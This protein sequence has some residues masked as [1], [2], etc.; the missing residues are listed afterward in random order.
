MVA[1]LLLAVRPTVALFGEKDYQ[2]LAVIRQLVRDLA[3]PIEIVGVPI[4]RDP[5]GL[6]LSSRNAYL[7]V[8]E[9]ARAV[10]LPRALNQAREA[11]RAEPKDVAKALRT[12][13][14]RLANA[15]FGPIDYVALTD[16]ETLEPLEVFDRPARLAAAATLGTTRLIDNLAV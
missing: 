3:L 4:V 8:D 7:T 1:K 10:E 15:G 6:A 13:R 9:R 16:A 2:Q 14:T 5:D 11:I 12:A